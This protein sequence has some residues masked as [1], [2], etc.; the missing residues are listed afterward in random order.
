MSLHNN[1][2]DQGAVKKG[3]SLVKI[4]PTALSVRTL[5]SVSNNQRIDCLYEEITAIPRQG[6]VK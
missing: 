5:G 3:A 2:T 4:G 6:A 1:I